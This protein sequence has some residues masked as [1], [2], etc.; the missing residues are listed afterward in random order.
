MPIDFFE[1]HCIFWIDILAIKF[2][3]DLKISQ[4]S[5]KNP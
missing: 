1:M 4:L 2:S 5:M 3:N